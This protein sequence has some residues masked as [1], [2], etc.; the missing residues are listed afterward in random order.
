MTYTYKTPKDYIERYYIDHSDVPESHVQTQISISLP[1]YLIERLTKESNNI[2]ISRSR[3]AAE[4]LEM[5]LDQID[6]T[7][8]N[9]YDAERIK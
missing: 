7:W 1:N 8:D 5:A 3:L 9:E 6:E 2:G 4:L